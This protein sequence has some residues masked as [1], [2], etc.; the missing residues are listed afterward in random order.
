MSTGER[1]DLELSWA[2]P[3]TEARAKFYKLPNQ[4]GSAALAVSNITRQNPSAAIKA[5]EITS[6]F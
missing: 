5:Q 2:S 1:I 3:T 4:R 6:L